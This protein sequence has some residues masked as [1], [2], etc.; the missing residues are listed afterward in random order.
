MSGTV[1]GQ[2][3]ATAAPT[4]RRRRLAA[5]SALVVAFIVGGLVLVLVSP[6]EWSER[7]PLDAASPAPDGARAIVRLLE[8][9]AGVEVVVA[10]GIDE[11]I[12]D[13]DAGGTLALGATAPLADADLRRLVD[14][15]DGVL[16]LSP[17]ARDLRLL[18]DD[19][20][21]RGRGDGGEVAPSCSLPVASR[22]GAIVPGAAY[23]PGDA[24]GCYPVAEGAW[25]LLTSP[26]GDRVAVDGTALLANE[27][28]DRAGNAALALALLGG[29]ERVVWYLPTDA[30]AATEP[31]TLGE[32]TPAWVTPA[33][34]LAAL[35]VV[36]AGLW[37]G[38]RFGPLVAEDLPVTVRAGETMEGRARLYAR[39]ADSRHAAHLLRRGAE[40]RM[41]RRL[42]LPRTAAS[43]QIAD[44]AAA[45]LGAEPTAIRA[46]LL[47]EPQRD[48]ELVAWGERLRHLEAAVDAAV[49]TER[50]PS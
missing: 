22:A 31:K 12:A 3:S 28:L 26:A 17:A 19:A 43:E 35:G 18:F 30:D 42:G 10:T 37:R 5:W 49:R 14:A 47:A 13:V 8:D 36:A 29:G 34:V 24:T 20:A 21:F 38:R 4:A 50:T 6:D 40:R 27:H 7:P 16:L 44:A 11:A 39:A 33:I 48:R 25:A 15:A 45:R 2:Q 9:R 23:A 46:L 32:L 41:A 1:S